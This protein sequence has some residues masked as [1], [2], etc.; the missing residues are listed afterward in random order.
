MGAYPPGP[1]GAAMDQ[2]YFSPGDAS[3]FRG[4]TSAPASRAQQGRVKPENPWYMSPLPY[5]V[6]IVVA[7]GVI[8]G[9]FFL[10]KGKSHSGSVVGAKPTVLDFYT[11]T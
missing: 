3:G 9:V 5:A 1:P 10:S 2:P 7:I 6:A 4:A 11:D 8:A